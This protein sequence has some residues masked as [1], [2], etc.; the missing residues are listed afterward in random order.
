MAD[1]SEEEMEEVA[2]EELAD[3]AGL[4][5]LWIVLGV[6]WIVLALVILQFDDA[7]VTLIGV[8]VGAMFLVAGIQEFLIAS[9]A[10][11]WRWLWITFGVIFVIAGLVALFNPEDTFSAVADILGFLFLLV[12]IFWLIEAFATRDFNDLWWLGLVAGILMLILA[13]WTAG[14]FF[15]EKAYILLVFTGIWALFHGFMD[16][17]KAFQIKKFGKLAA[18]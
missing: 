2:R 18:G 14:Q 16:I 10:E 8:L 1:T 13:F 17:F 15:I 3:M 9:V 5:W 12:G 11:G 4:W 6:I 7:S